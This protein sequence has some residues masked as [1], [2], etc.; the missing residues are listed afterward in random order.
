MPGDSGNLASTF[1]QADP[2][3]FRQSVLL[4][5]IFSEHLAHYI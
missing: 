4:A 5:V 3:D 2:I 1:P